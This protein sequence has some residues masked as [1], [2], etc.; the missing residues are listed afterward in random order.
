MTLIVAAALGVTAP[1]D[2][3]CPR[4]QHGHSEQGTSVHCLSAE[5]YR[6]WQARRAER[7]RELA[8][9]AERRRKRLQADERLRRK[10]EERKREERRLA[11]RRQAE[12]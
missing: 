12:R 3:V 7:R 8:R 4:D 11:E 9:A 5:E 10:R 6:A 1:A 2:S